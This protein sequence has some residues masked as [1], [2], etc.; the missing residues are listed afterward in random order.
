VT[1]GDEKVGNNIQIIVQRL[2]NVAISYQEIFNPIKKDLLIIHS[3][4]VIFW[5]GSWYSIA[6]LQA[7]FYVYAIKL[8]SV[9]FDRESTIESEGHALN[10][11]VPI[12]MLC[13]LLATF[14]AVWTTPFLARV[15]IA[16][17]TQTYITQTAIT[18]EVLEVIQL[19][20]V[21]GKWTRLVI[22]T[23]A[24]ILLS[25]LQAQILGCLLMSIIGYERLYSATP[26]CFDYTLGAI[27]GPNNLDGRVT[28]L[29]VCAII[30]VLWQ[31][32]HG[33]QSSLLGFIVPLGFLVKADTPE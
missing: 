4:L 22:G 12:R 9:L 16:I 17:T 24:V 3:V 21:C 6:L 30:S 14:Y 23:V 13:M 7:W 20:M 31:L 29:W 5:G 2:R 33:F 15:T 19:D 10:I 11:I 32:L 18:P 28:F 1:F 25:L 26:V 8:A 27:K